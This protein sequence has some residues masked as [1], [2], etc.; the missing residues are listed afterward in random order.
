M[1]RKGLVLKVLRQDRA[2]EKEREVLK[3]EGKME[4]GVKMGA[5]SALINVCHLF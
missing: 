2:Q 1:K 4:L 5:E 3:N